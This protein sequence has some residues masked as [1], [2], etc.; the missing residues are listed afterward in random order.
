VAGQGC[1]RGP[2]RLAEK[3]ADRP[4]GPP[5][6]T[7]AS[8]H[9]GKVQV[10]CGHPRPVGRSVKGRGAI[11]FRML[12]ARFVGRERAGGRGRK[13]AEAGGQGLGC[14]EKNSG[15]LLA[16]CRALMVRLNAV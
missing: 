11:S 5:L 6:G 14:P 8:D 2:G 3:A 1:L 15:E 12:A 7:R 9:D 10:V 16:G 13:F 4:A